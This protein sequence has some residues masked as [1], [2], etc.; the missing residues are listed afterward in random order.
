MSSNINTHVCKHAHTQTWHFLENGLFQLVFIL[1]HLLPS[2]LQSSHLK[3][4]SIGQ[5]LKD[6]STSFLTKCGWTA[7]LEFTKCRVS[8]NC[9]A[10]EPLHQDVCHGQW[11]EPGK[12]R[13]ISSAPNRLQR[14]CSSQR[15]F[16]GPVVFPYNK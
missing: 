8:E 1:I 4:S 11:Q 6:S 3:M 13:G 10:A 9:P 14:S 5:E 7:Q 15:V 16:G 2:G 12:A